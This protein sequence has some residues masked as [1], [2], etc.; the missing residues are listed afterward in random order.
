MFVQTARRA[1]AGEGPGVRIH[2]GVRGRLLLAFFGISGFALLGAMTAIY[3]LGRIGEAVDG[4][5]QERVPTALASQELSRQA[6]RIVAAAPALLTVTTE[7]EHEESSQG[8]LTEVD[9]LNTLLADLKRDRAEGAAFAALGPLVERL[10][11]NL[12][13]LNRL[14][15]SRLEAAGRKNLLLRGL[16]QTH[17]ETE[18]LL[19]PWIL[20]MEG[21][22]DQ[23]RTTI[24]NPDLAIDDRVAADRELDRSLPWLRSLQKAQLLISSL[25]ETLQRAALT[26][27]PGSLRIMVFR[28]RQSLDELEQ[29]T[30]GLDPKLQ[31]LLLV[32]LEEFRGYLTGPDSIPEIRARELD[33]VAEAQRLLQENIALS[34]Q[35][36]EAVDRLVDGANQD[37]AAANLDALSVQRFGTGALGVVVALSLACSILIVWLYVGRNLIGRLSALSASMLAIAGGNLRAPLPATGDDEIGRMAGALTVFRDTAVE[38]ED[39]NLREIAQ[40]R[41]RL[42]DAIESISEGFALYDADDRL[43]LCNSRYRELLYPGIADVMQPGTPFETIVRRAGERGLVENSKGRLEEWVAE[44]L[45]SHRDPSGVLVQHRSHNRWIQIS[46]RKTTDGDTVTVYSDITDLKVAR[47]EAMR[48]AETKSQFLANMSHELRTPLNAII[49]ITEML[50]EDA[51][52]EGQDDLVEPLGRIHRAGNHLLHLIN[53]ILDLSKIEAGK[54]ELHLEEVALAAAMRDAAATAE[55]LAAKDGN[56]LIVDCPGDIG[57]IR[58]DATRLR[59]IILNL[60]SNACKFTEN[61][62]VRLEV[63]REPGWVTITITDTG[64]GMTP[65]QVGRLFQEFS[66]ADSSTTRRYG[67]TGLGLAISRKLARLMNGDITVESTSGKGS[68]FTVRLPAKA[69]P[70]AQI[71]DSSEPGAR[72]PGDQPPCKPVAGDATKVLVIDD[73]ETVRDLMRRFL[74]REGFDVVTAR[75]GAEGLALARQLRPALITLDV[76]MPGLDGW[77][78]LQALKADPELAAIPVVMLTIVDE[79][80]RGYALGAADYVTKPIPRDRLRALLARYCGRGPGKHVLIVDDDPE[81]RRWLERVLTAEGWQVSEAEHGREALARVRERRPDLILLDLLMPE[82]DGFEFLAELHAEP[83]GPRIPVV[84]V[85]AADLTEDD[86]HRLNGGVERIL[87]KQT[88]SREELLE[89]LRELVGRAVP[90]RLVEPQGAADD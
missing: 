16:L 42:V 64:I 5:T 61:G 36:K 6:E 22:V 48:A 7:A 29:L 67:G 53:E 35:L 44:R 74:A 62:E 68:T 27:E 47:D 23:W 20:V 26:D 54:L 71:A 4:I 11:V 24:T 66:Q 15:E 30:A 72:V 43:V 40:A 86:H 58:A 78:V 87:L 77:E 2:L 69:A 10:R 80:N 32:R 39:K 45:A 38:V 14:V 57:S 50:R 73:E 9:A 82:M 1:G 85:T 37:I 70:K 56:R 65:E 89:I 59:Q 25:T 33:L 52:D 63:R 18:R 8:I 3:S 75:D 51:E 13:A 34:E 17:T 88:Y 28:L 49:G 79:K 21:A 12:E 83:A 46:E 76:M 19:A 41:Q 90:T 81:V 84:V 60:L 55:P 31:P